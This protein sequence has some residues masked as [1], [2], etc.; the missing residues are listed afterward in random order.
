[1]THPAPHEDLSHLSDETFRQ[2][3]RDW[4]AANYPDEIRH[5]P[6]R[7]HWHENR[8]WYMALAQQ[9]WL[10]PGWPREH[11]GMGLS[12]AK[13]LIMMEEQERYGCARISDFGIIMLGPLLI[14]YGTDAQ[15]ETFLPA[16]LE[17]R[18]IWAQGYS[19]PGAGSDLASLRTSARRDGAE[20]VVNGQKTW[21]TLGMDANWI[22]LL[23]R[24]STEGR[25]QAGIS[26]LLVPM[27]S[28]GV[29]VRPIRNLDLH[30]EFCD[31]FFD[32]VRVPV[33]NLVGEEN[34]GWAMAK[35]LLGFERI[36]VGSPK[37]S[38]NALA[39]LREVARQQGLAGDPLFLDQYAQVA[40]RLDDL[41]ALYTHFADMLRAGRPLGPDVSLLKIVQTELYQSI[42]ELMQ[43]IAGEGGGLLDRTGPD[44]TIN[45]ASMAIQSRPST[46]YGGSNEIQR[47]IL[48]GAVLN[49]P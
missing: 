11:G 10:C 31:V 38:E 5:P 22:F 25:K 16:I 4:I 36:F 49:L 13:Q 24:T 27:D 35:S 19:E 23:V 41:K 30:D 34:A 28:P 48:A 42:C 18:H 2:V 1:M 43:E 33:D 37:Q 32:D 8:P 21:T 9:G 3:V 15:R 12:P 14:R 47:N 40:M 7:L 29:T 6:K 46:I 17:G 39:R 45:P 44:G 26:F 20:F